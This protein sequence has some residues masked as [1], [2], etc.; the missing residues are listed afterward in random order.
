MGFHKVHLH[1]IKIMVE[2]QQKVKG[3]GGTEGG[4]QARLIKMRQKMRMKSQRVS[5]LM[6]SLELMR[7]KESL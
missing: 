7:Q 5:S 3:L 2:L 4:N 6:T 1:P